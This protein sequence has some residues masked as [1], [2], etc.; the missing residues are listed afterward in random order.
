MEKKK[1][2]VRDMHGHH[3]VRFAERV[4][5]EAARTYEAALGRFLITYA[6]ELGLE[7]E[8]VDGLTLR[9][10]GTEE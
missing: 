4:G 5:F 6:E 10:V 3:E 9:P 2:V 7:I 8:F 1:I